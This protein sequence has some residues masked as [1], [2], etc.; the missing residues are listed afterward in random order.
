MPRIS[1][2]VSKLQKLQNQHGDLDVIMEIQQGILEP[3][4][5]SFVVRYTN[6]EE[7]ENEDGVVKV[8]K[9]NRF[10]DKILYVNLKEP[11]W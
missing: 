1:E 3:L 7:I 8:R 9:S 6:D 11:G 5:D 2:L 10:C 4:C